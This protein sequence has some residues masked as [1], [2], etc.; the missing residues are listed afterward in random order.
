MFDATPLLRRYAG[1]RLGALSRH[2]PI[3]E[4]RRV[5][6]RLVA[7]ARFTQFGRDH[8]FEAI[9]TVADYQQQ[10][11]LRR[12]E[13]FWRDYWQSAFPVLR[14]VTWPG[15]IPF[16]ALSS[17][18]TSG[19]TKYIP[20]S[21]A[22]NRSNTR[23]GADL[24]AYH[25]QARPDSRVLGGLSFML[26]GSTDLT[27]LADGVQAGDLSGI[28][29]R[30]MPWWA[31]RRYFPPESLALLSD[32]ERKVALLAERSRGLDIRMIG[33]TPSWLLIYFDR[34][35]SGR[36]DARLVDYFPNLELLVHGGVNF[37]P[38]RGLF[39]R[40][41][42]GSQALLRE[43]YPASEGFVAAADRGPGEGLRL[44][45]DNG[46]FFEFVPIDELDS[47][48]PSRHWLGT[49]ET[50][51]EYAVVITTCAGLWSYLVGD[52]I[53]FVEQR[54]P[55]LLVT[56][57]TAYMLSAFGEHLTDAEIESAMAAAADQEQLAVVDF[58]VGPVFPDGPGDLGGHLYMVEF[59]DEPDGERLARFAAALDAALMRSNDDYRA[60]RA[61][62]FGLRGPRVQALAPGAF[63]AW[64][65]AQGRLGGQNKVPRVLVD[66]DRFKALR[67]GLASF[68]R[69]Q[70]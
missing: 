12:Y 3:V 30:V 52:T 17:G 24:L 47:P 6:E 62:G 23:A 42:A 48:Q 11:P 65:K 14:D 1:R 21:A 38:Y 50:G 2:D 10:V 54:P 59:A 27:T 45:V 41:L 18:T 43:V 32:W 64:M 5:L 15:L 8:R 37:A 39:E 66:P 16:F 19:T 63:A 26:G 34:L 51:V 46:L 13:D 61:D 25:L 70:S 20:C 68:V 60:H 22:M 7:R 44:F 58:T 67:A 29:V 4:Q 57:R 31:R 36:K 35:A 40:W 69:G 33:G 55:R 28:A 56:G 49:I 9:R 53:R